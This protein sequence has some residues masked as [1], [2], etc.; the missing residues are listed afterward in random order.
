MNVLKRRL[1]TAGEQLGELE[2]RITEIQ[3][4]EQRGGKRLKK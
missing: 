4:E 3:T 1:N 2:D